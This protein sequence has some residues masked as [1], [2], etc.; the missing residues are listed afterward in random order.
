MEQPKD[1]WDVGPSSQVHE[2]HGPEG[3]SPF[4][5]NEGKYLRTVIGLDSPHRVR[6][7]LMHV[8][9]YGY[10]KDFAASSVMLACRMKLFRGRS[11]QARVDSA[12]D[13]FKQWCT[14]RKESTS[15]SNFSPKVFK[16]GQTSGN[17]SML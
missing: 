14:N 15:L 8:Y 9:A 13:L 4:K 16:M 17:N 2:W 7:D 11:M 3:R 1:W 6:A 12:F 10:G 5:T